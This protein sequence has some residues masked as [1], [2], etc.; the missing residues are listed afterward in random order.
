MYISGG[1]LK[2]LARTLMECDKEGWSPVI[3]KKMNGD[4]HVF[5]PWREW[6]ITPGGNVK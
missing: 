5:T 3:T 4:L 6:T 1:A 2:S